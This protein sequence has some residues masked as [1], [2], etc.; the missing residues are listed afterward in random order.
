MSADFQANP[1]DISW[2]RVVFLVIQYYELQFLSW[3]NFHKF[4]CVIRMQ[5]I[6]ALKSFLLCFYECQI[7][8]N[9]VD[10]RNLESIGM[11]LQEEFR[12][13][14]L[15]STEM[16]SFVSPIETVWIT[17]WLYFMCL[18]KLMNANRISTV[19][20]LDGVL[21]RWSLKLFVFY[22]SGFA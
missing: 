18:F 17:T 8:A 11:R 6:S 13:I 20:I 16:S 2:Q 10:N 21:R 7:L 22:Y 1:T 12:L 15:K 19:K 4:C 5:P 9:F 3:T 14:V